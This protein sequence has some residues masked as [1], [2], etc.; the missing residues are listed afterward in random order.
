[1]IL[2]LVTLAAYHWNLVAPKMYRKI[3]R[4][5]S[6]EEQRRRIDKPRLIDS[7]TH[8]NENDSP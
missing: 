5:L 8:W 2:G 1:M 7:A 4:Y 3:G 6:S